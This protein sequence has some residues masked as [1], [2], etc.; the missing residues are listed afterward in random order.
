M[1]TS[2][3]P[4]WGTTDEPDLERLIDQARRDLAARVS[5]AAETIEVLEARA[6]TWPDAGLGCD[7][8][9]MRYKQVPT[10][11]ALIRL[12]A[13]GRVYEYHSGGGRGPFLCGPTPGRRRR[14][15]SGTQGPGATGP[16]GGS[17]RT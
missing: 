4:T 13:G 3:A 2:P 10:D 1:D 9:H 12:G 16:P 8:P 5:A 7:R 6:V 15:S 17:E 14:P 11:G